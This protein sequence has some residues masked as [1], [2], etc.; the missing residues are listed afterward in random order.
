[1]KKKGDFSLKAVII[2]VLSI[3]LLFFLAKIVMNIINKGLG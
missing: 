3:L 1:M 2:I